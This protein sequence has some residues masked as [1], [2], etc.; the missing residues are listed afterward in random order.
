MASTAVNSM[1]TAIGSPS[2]MKSTRTV[3]IAAV[4]MKSAAVRR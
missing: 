2:K 1:A 3:K 4:V